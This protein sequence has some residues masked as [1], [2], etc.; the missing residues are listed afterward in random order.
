MK[1]R[2]GFVS[3]SSSSSFCLYGT[4]LETDELKQ[5]YANVFGKSENDEDDE[6]EYDSLY[7]MCA[8]L[9]D[10]VGLSYEVDGECG[11]YYFGQYYN[12]APDD[13][14]FGQFRNEIKEIIKTNFGENCTVCHHEGEIPC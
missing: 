13:K 3:N 9:A 10:K 11:Y 12:S 5:A 14:T 8:E 1:V 7:E 6:D 2:N 4:S